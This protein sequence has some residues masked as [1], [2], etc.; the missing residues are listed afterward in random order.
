MERRDENQAGEI[1][2][3]VTPLCSTASSF[4]PPTVHLL[5]YSCFRPLVDVSHPIPSLFIVIFLSKSPSKTPH[6]GLRTVTISVY[7]T[8]LV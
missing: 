2:D 7:V 4:P 3:L 5:L 1:S 6:A 8:W